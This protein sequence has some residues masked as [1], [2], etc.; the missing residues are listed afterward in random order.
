MKRTHISGIL[1]YLWYKK[2]LTYNIFQVLV[3]M[4][5]FVKIFLQFE[6]CKFMKSIS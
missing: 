2:E 3:K 5:I 1:L 6:N 4:C